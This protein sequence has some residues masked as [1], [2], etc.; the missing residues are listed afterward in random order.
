[1]ELWLVTRRVA[2]GLLREDERG[3]FH[4][5][6]DLALDAAGRDPGYTY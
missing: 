4:P 3:R 1:L 5:N 2:L 6:A